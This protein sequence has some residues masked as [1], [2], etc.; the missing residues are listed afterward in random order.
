MHQ[1]IDGDPEESDEIR[2]YFFL[3]IL[4][5]GSFY[6]E[7][8]LTDEEIADLVSEALKQGAPIQ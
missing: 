6:T 2:E 8:N 7:T 1:T 4:P 3:G 5:D